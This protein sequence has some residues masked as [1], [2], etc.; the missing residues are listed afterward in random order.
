M[1]LTSQGQ[2]GLQQM[3]F[4]NYVVDTKDRCSGYLWSWSDELVHVH[5]DV[6]RMVRRICQVE[7]LHNPPLDF[8]LVQPVQAHPILVG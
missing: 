6:Q 2:Q 4:I 3:F 8:I 5:D 7:Q 1:H